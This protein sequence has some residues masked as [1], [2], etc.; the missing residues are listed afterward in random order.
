MEDI[1]KNI[2]KKRN[3]DVAFTAIKRSVIET[4]GK[5]AFDILEHASR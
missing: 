4:I 5:K 1:K 3:E 2:S